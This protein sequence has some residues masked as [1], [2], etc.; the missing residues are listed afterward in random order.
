M[1]GK[2]RKYTR[3]RR[4]FEYDEVTYYQTTDRTSVFKAFLSKGRLCYRPWYVRSGNVEAWQR[5]NEDPLGTGGGVQ[6]AFK[7]TSQTKSFDHT[8]RIVKKYLAKTVSDI[9]VLGQT[10]K[11]RSNIQKRLFQCT[12][13][14]KFRIKFATESLT[15]A[16]LV[17][18]F[19][20]V[21]EYNVH[22]LLWKMG[23]RMR[24]H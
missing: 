13:C 16:D 1:S 24:H 6:Q 11:Q 5:D 15:K 10:L 4:T 14:T 7:A 12:V 20:P 9:K 3:V 18:T 23:V 8:S 21:F 22:D 2:A 17:D 19:G